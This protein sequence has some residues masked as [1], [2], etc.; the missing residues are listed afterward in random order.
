[1]TFTHRYIYTYI[2]TY[3]CAYNI[4]VNFKGNWTLYEPIQLN[5]N[6]KY[7]QVIIDMLKF[8]FQNFIFN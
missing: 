5:I 6:A 3:M 8:N 7:S 1:M 2:C 4:N